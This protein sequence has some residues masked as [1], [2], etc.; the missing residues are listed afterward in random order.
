MGDVVSVHDG[1]HPC[2][3]IAIAL[4]A[5]EEEVLGHQEVPDRE[6]QLIDHRTSTRTEILDR[7]PEH[8]VGGC[9]ERLRIDVEGTAAPRAEPKAIEGRGEAVDMQE[10][11]QEPKT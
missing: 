6:A 9:E 4:R 8:V 1:P 10:K 5:G 2:G 3:G 11:P 7:R